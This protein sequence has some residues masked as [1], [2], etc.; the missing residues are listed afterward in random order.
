MLQFRKHL[1]GLLYKK[2]TVW[3]DQLIP[4]GTDW[5]AKL[6]AHVQQPDAALILVTPD[7]LASEWCRLE[8]ALIASMQKE[9]RIKKIFWVQLELSGWR[10]TELASFQSWNFNIDEPLSAITDFHARERNIVKIC[11][12]IAVELDAVNKVLDSDFAFVR[13][14]ILDQSI[15]NLIVDSAISE[16]KGIFATVCRGRRN[17]QEVAIKVIRRAPMKLSDEFSHHVKS[18]MKLMNQ[19][20][21]KVLDRFHVEAGHEEYEVLVEEFIGAIRLDKYLEEKKKGKPFTIDEVAVILRRA[22]EALKE[23]HDDPELGGSNKTYG[24]LAPQYVYYDERSQK[25]LL[26]TVGMSNFLWHTMG[27]ERLGTWQDDGP[28]VAAYIPPEQAPSFTRNEKDKKQPTHH[29]DQYLLGQ[30]AFEAQCRL[31]WVKFP[32]FR[33]KKAVRILSRIYSSSR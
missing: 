17:K 1:E 32:H 14:I 15:S 19:C 9:G 24:L 21:I 33:G 2:G 31:E 7:F 26:P 20:F 5:E 25:L 8:V 6:R 30:L 12:E 27:W 11:E 29:T 13:Q 16:G 23:F 4:R 28:N 18:R 22:A 10:G 3:S